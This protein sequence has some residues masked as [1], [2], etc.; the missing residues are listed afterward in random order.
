MWKDIKGFE[1]IYIISDL[2]EVY[3]KDRMC[4]DSLGRKRFRKGI[5][6]NPDIAPNG[7]YRVTL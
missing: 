6:I 7:Y 4:I 1:D 2:G 3:S 5:K